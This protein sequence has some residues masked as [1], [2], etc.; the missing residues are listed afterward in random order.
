M[1][2]LLRK[3]GKTLSSLRLTV[4]LLA[5][6]MLL[7]FVATLSQVHLG[8]YEVQIQFFRSWI[9][10]CDVAP[11][12]WHIAIP[13]PGGMLLGSLL[14]INLLAAHGA[15]FKLRWNKAGM[16]LIHGGVLLLLLGELFTAILGKESQMVIDEGQIVNYSTFPREIELAVIDTSTPGEEL[17]HAIPQSRL[18]DGA[19]FSLDGITLRV[20]R[21]FL[22][23]EILPET[24]TGHHFD[25][26]RAN[27][28][29]GKPYAVQGKSRVTAMDLRDISAAFVDIIPDGGKPLG[30]WLLSNALKDEQPFTVGGKSWKIAIR[31]RRSYHPFAIKLIDF[32]H[33]RYLGTEVPKN[34][35]SKIRV[36]NPETGENREDLI[37][38]NH[39]LRYQGLTFYQQ[40]FENNDTTSIFQ[41]VRNPVWTVPYIACVMVG[42]GLLWVFSQH[43]F[44]AISR[45]KPATD[46]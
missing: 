39:P 26:T 12:S 45:R 9:A 36:L 18:K 42:G 19:S 2:T 29:V 1:L 17:V 24:T 44:K 10:W 34:F 3:F 27:Q 30:R 23:C 31:Q 14:V 6:A 28:G 35:S 11:G 16:I 40:G 15:R 43:L 13:L 8:I 41:V 25:P 33:D 5:L 38:M 7:I 37:Y 4:T 21:Y 20:E 32:S 22:N 46:S